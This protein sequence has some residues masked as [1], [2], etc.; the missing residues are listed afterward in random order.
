M[1]P[2]QRQTDESKIDVEVMVKERP[3][4]TAEVECEWS[5]APND[6]GKPSLVS[7]VPGMPKARHVCRCPSI[8]DAAMRPQDDQFRICKA[9]CH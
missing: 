5:I 4:Q 7:I 2:R 6:S 3:M 1:L 8:H 9:R